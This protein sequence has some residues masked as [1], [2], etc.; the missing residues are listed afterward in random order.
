MTSG[1]EASIATFWLYGLFSHEEHAFAFDEAQKYV[2]LGSDVVISIG[3]SNS[4]RE[5]FRGF[6]AKV[7]FSYESEEQPGIELTCM[8]IKGIMMASALSKQLTAT[9][10]SDAVNEILGEARYEKII[11]SLSISNTPDKKD[12]GA[13]GGMGGAAGGMGAGGAEGGEV[14]DKTIEMVDE[15]EYEFVVKAAKKFNFEFYSV[16]GVVFFRKAK[17]DTTVLIELSPMAGLISIRAEYDI[18]GLVE[19]IEVRTTDPGTGKV[20]SAKIDTSIQESLVD[21]TIKEMGSATWQ[22]R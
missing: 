20:V 21:E 8:D 15:S 18:T 3:Y 12:A 19:E 10:W 22:S 13:D 4:V 16:G 11:S 2:T 17:S 7:S 5:I 14:T 6:I 9:S 1:F